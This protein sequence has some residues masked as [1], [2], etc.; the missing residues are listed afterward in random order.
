MKTNRRKFLTQSALGSA[1]SY[2]KCTVR[3]RSGLN[4]A[5]TPQAGHLPIKLISATAQD[6][7]DGAQHRLRAETRGSPDEGES[8]HDQRHRRYVIAELLRPKIHRGLSPYR[9]GTAG[10]QVFTHGALGRQ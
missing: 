10:M 7:R 2:V 6:D 5:R 3:T 8:R 9:S 4:G 1:D